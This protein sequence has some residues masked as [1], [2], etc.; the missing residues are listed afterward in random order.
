M[1]PAEQ[2]DRTAALAVAADRERVSADLEVAIVRGWQ[3][4]RVRP[5]AGRRSPQPTMIRT[6]LA[7][8]EE[9]GR[10]TLTDMRTVVR[11]LRDAP[12]DP[13]RVSTTS[14]PC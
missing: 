13:R 3:G 5:W 4:G 11:T 2:R 14:P 6:V 10:Q 8:I 12:T 9:R 7:E 1:E